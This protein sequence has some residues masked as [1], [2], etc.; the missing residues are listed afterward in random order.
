MVSTV[1]PQH[2]KV[3][4][5]ESRE[6][7]A[8]VAEWPKRSFKL[9]PLE[10]SK[11]TIRS[12][13]DAGRS[14][15]HFGSGT[16]ARGVDFCC[17][18]PALGACP[19]VRIGPEQ[20]PPRTPRELSAHRCIGFRNAGDTLSPWSFEKDGHAETVKVSPSVVVNDGD[21][22]VQAALAGMG[23]AYMLEDLAAPFLGDGRLIE[24]LADW[25]PRFPGYHAFY[26]SRR[27]PARAFTLFLESLRQE[28]REGR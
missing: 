5:R 22:L 15:H 12:A 17:E 11:P 26:S 28:T 9:R 24:V 4:P 13:A 10:E 21:A 23:L 16:R 19:F 1:A 25:C 8:A 3:S 2:G 6:N 14:G 18:L 7:A 20:Q 27:Q